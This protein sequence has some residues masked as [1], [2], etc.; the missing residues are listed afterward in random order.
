M[1]GK[2][3]VN[4]M[5]RRGFVAG[6]SAG[7]A[8]ALASCLRTTPT[9]P[10]GP[11]APPAARYAQRLP[12]VRLQAWEA[13]RYGMFI[14]FGISTFLGQEIPDGLARATTY[15]PDRL[16]VGS[17]IRIA[18]DAGMRYAV[19]T[20]KHVA[21]HCLWP[22]R[23]T[24]YTVANSGDKTDV[25]AA[26]VRACAAHGVRPGLYYCA[27]DNHHR[28]GSRTPSDPP[29]WNAAYTTSRYH[30]FQTAQLTELLTQYGP[31]EELWIDIPGVLGRGYRT[32]LYGH[33]ARLQP[34]CVVMM[35]NGFT[36]G[37]K[38]D[39]GYAWP[40]DLMALERTLPPAAG[41]PKVR[42]IEGKIY[43][44]PGEMCDPLGKTW[45]WAEGDRL[46]PDEVLAGILNACRERG[47]NLLL[48]VGP[49]RHGQIPSDVRDAL[50]RLRKSAGL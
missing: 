14:H 12:I 50:M 34:D 11:G 29:G 8:A 36:D 17:W 30:D 19:L 20:A 45:F 31:V 22:S 4:A 13:L 40:S 6:A 15:A 1:V 2:P 9:R 33:V 35:N 25:V 18:R 23:H 41:F 44:I 37:T 48:D 38:Y 27:W 39:A 16:D 3:A 42:D 49:D 46:R 21:G 43:Y 28:F 24:D 10:A 26:F 7:A 32:F 47:V 5:T